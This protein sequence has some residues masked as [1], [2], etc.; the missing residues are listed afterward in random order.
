MLKKLFQLLPGA[1]SADLFFQND[2]PSRHPPLLGYLL[3]FVLFQFIWIGFL[4]SLPHTHIEFYL[5]G[6]ASFVALLVLH[7]HF[8]KVMQ[9]RIRFQQKL[10]NAIPSPIFYKDID[11]RFLGANNAFLDLTGIPLH[12]IL[13]KTS[14]ELFTERTAAVMHDLNQQAITSDKIAERELQLRDP[15]GF[16]WDLIL[17]EKVIKDDLCETSAIIGSTF[18]ITAWKRSESMTHEALLKIDQIFNT[19]ADGMRIITT[20]FTCEMVNN[21]LLTMQKQ[22]RNQV[23]YKKCFESFPGTPCH[24]ERCSLT[25]IMNGTERIEEEV[26]KFTTTGE[27]FL[28]LLTATPYRDQTGKLLGIV[29]NFKDITERERTLFSLSQAMESANLALERADKANEAK[30]QFLAN[31]S[32]EVRTPLNGILGMTALTMG[33]ELTDKQQQYLE[34]IQKSGERLLDLLN[35]VLDFS[36]LEAGKFK[37]ESESFILRDL[38]D[39]VFT[40]VAMQ[41]QHRGIASN[42]IISP[43]IPDQWFGDAIRLRQILANLLDN[44]AKFTNQ[45]SVSLRV[46]PAGSQDDKTLLHFSIQDTGI[47]IPDDR[48]KMIFA[49]FSQV[50]SSMTRKYGG[51]GLG[52]TICRQIVELMDG[53][54]WIDSSAG[55]GSTFHFSIPLKQHP[56]DSARCETER[57]A[58]LSGNCGMF[59]I[60]VVDDDYINQVVAE[61]ILKKAGLSSTIA[62]NGEEALAVLAREQIDLVLMDMLMPIMDGYTAT[63]K[64]RAREKETGSH[65][66]IIAL[67]G[68]AYADDAERCRAAGVDDHLIK[69]FQE[70]KL[71][72]TIREHLPLKEGAGHKL[73]R[74]GL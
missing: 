38:L 32:H 70:E 36:K 12:K 66:P 72:A 26:W 14:A 60:L 69:P 4:V 5:G 45:G 57:L 28:C 49:P 16:L 46:T 44:A 34:M 24:T 6:T 56:K 3:V 64:I 30:S 40:P 10:L 35:Q 50:D 20:D 27:K 65:L 17:Y 22:K 61:T 31:M 1:P 2:E 13:N 19:T 52:L 48:Q 51:T 41:L 39:E 58:G 8:T 11:D 42:L 53:R 73:N 71:L 15:N 55:K 67:T 54:I 63:E 59:H 29:E 7:G 21:T 9:S 18:D 23:L 47:G 62:K 43:D 68:S 74:G 25:R 37:L 33:T